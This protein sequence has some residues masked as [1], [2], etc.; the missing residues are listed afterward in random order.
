MRGTVGTQ[1]TRL[2]QRQS[3][4]AVG[5]DGASAAGVHGGVVG[6]GDDHLV[7]QFFQAAGHPFA[8][9][10]RFEQDLRP[11]LVP[12]GGGEPLALSAH[13][14]FDQLTLRSQDANVAGP[15]TEVYANMVHGWS[16]CDCA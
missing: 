8:L 16:S 2:G 1:A 3:I 10:A 14:P 13:A 6:V 12:K 15:P 7:P 9:C 4:S 11:W 5:L